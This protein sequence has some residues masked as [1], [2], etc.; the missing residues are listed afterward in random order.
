MTDVLILGGTGWLSGQIARG[1]VDAGARVT[2]LARG[3]RPAPEG[4]VLVAGDRAEPGVYD[5]LAEHDWDEIVEISSIPAHVAAA[6]AA[7]APRAKHWTYISSVSVYAANNHEGDDESAELSLAAEPGDE[8]DYSR[9]KVA[10]EESVLDAL[11]D[12]AAI[13]RPGLIVG[14]GDPTDRFGYWVSRFALAG[15]EP[16]LVPDAEGRRAQVID[17]RDLAE[18]VI[19]VGH[20]R[21]TGTANAVGPSLDLGEV[22]QQAAATAG[23]TGVRIAATDDDLAAHEVA[24]WAGPRSLPL[25][26]PA[27]LPGFSTRSHAAYTAAGGRHRDLNDTLTDTLADERARGLARERR[28]GLTRPD[29]LSILAALA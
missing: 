22:L 18:F 9:A 12:R 3:E 20:K 27:D 13:V 1:W 14:A 2:C 26:L 29:E 10:A 23:Y 6:V 11:G 28:S 7:L 25:W 15:S 8:Y 17:V 16:V 19:A 5:T 4:A 21:W 24:H